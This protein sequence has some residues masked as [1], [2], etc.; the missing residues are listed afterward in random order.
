M[1]L[2][3]LCA[4]RYGVGRHRRAQCWLALWTPWTA[5]ERAISSNLRR[6]FR[7]GGSLTLVFGQAVQTPRARVDS[8]QARLVRQ[9]LALHRKKLDESAFNNEMRALIGKQDAGN[10]LYLRLACQELRLHGVFDRLGDFLRQV[11]CPGPTFRRCSC[12]VRD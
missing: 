10:P 1:G 12:A 6:R 8:V 7:V 2:W 5:Y 3:Y 11:R 9:T 4:R